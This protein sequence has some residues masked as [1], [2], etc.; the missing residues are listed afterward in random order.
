ML[1]LNSK[2]KLKKSKLDGIEDLLQ[3]QGSIG[4]NLYDTCEKSV[5]DKVQ[6]SNTTDINYARQNV[7]HIP[8]PF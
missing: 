4:L 2:S 1:H 7:E 8:K 3:E 5:Q 6:D